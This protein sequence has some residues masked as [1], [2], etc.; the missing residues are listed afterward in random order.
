MVT[1]TRQAL[2]L[3]A[4]AIAFVYLG[5]RAAFTFNFTTPYAICVSIALFVAELYTGVL[6]L[7]YIL[8]VWW[9]S[10]PEQQPVLPDRTLDVYVPTYNEDAAMLR[11]TLRAC[12]AMDYPHR[13]FVLDDGRRPEIAA[14]AQELGVGYLTR[15]DN[16]HAKA[17][18]MN[19]A[20]KQ[21][22]GEFIVILDADHVPDA[23]F[24]TR[25]LGYFA[26]ETLAY[27]QTPH[28]FYNFDNFQ[29]RYN[30]RK[31]TYWDEGQLFYDVIQPGRNRW[32]AAIFAGS[33]AIFRRKALEEIGGFAFETITEDLHTGLRLHAR[34]WKS[35]AIAERLIAGQAAPDVTTFHS[36]RLRWGEGNLSILAYDNPLF[37]RGLSMAQ[38][39]CYLG[40]MIHWAGGPFLLILY[41]TPIL[42]LLTGVPPV[43]AFSWTFLVLIV[44][45]MT[46]SYVSFRA[47]SGGL[48]SYWNSQLFGMSNAW[49]S[50]RSVFRAMFWRRFQRFVVTSKRGRQSKRVL[51][52][53]WPQVTLL[54]LSM[55]ALCWGW[56][57]PISGISD[58]YY[59]PI[60]ASVWVV[61]HMMIAAVVIYRSL[62]QESRRFSYRHVV[63][64]PVAFEKNGVTGHGVCVDLNDA[65][66]G[67]M[68]FGQLEAGDRVQ[69]RLGVAGLNVECNAEV[70]WRQEIDSRMRV[71]TQGLRA[72][73]CGLCFL[74][75]APAQV[76]I[77]NEICWHYAVPKRYWQFGSRRQP[78]IRRLPVI[79][80]F[81]EQQAQAVT[82]EVT[83]GAFTALLDQAVPL[84]TEVSFNMPTPGEEVRGKARLVDGQPRNLAAR[85]YQLSRFQIESLEER[86][87]ETLE[88]LAS[89]RARRRLQPILDAYAP[90]RKVPVGSALLAAAVLVVMLLPAE[91]LFFKVYFRDDEFLNTIADAEEPISEADRDRL[92]SLYTRTLKGQRYPSND[93]LVLLENALLHQ[94]LLNEARAVTLVLAKRDT[95]NLNLQLAY[96]QALDDTGESKDA[97]REYL[98][99]MPRVDVKGIPQNR[100]S[101][102]RLAA[103]RAAAHAADYAQAEELFHEVMSDPEF[104]TPA[105]RN[106]LAGIFLTAGAPKECIRLY[107]RQTPDFDGQILLARAHLQTDDYVDAEKILKKLVA[108]RPRDL[109]AELLLLRAVVLQEKFSEA[110]RL[111]SRLFEEFPDSLAVRVEMGD[112]AL[113]IKDYPKALLLFQGLLEDKHP[114]GNDTDKVLHGYINAAA[115]VRDTSAIK[116]EIVARVV[117][118]FTSR[119]AP[120]PEYLARLAWIL[121]RTDE[122]GQAANILK[123]LLTDDAN[124]AG[125][126]ER[127]VHALQQAGRLKDAEAYLRSLPPSPDVRKMFVELYLAEKDY[128]AA[129]R[130]CEEGLRINPYA[131]RASVLL[132]QVKLSQHDPKEARRLLERVRGELAILPANRALLA[133]TLQWAGDPA[134]AL[135]EYHVLLDPNI[136]Q[137]DL[138]PGFLGAAAAVPKLSKSDGELIERIADQVLSKSNDALTLARLGWDLHRLDKRELSQKAVARALE[139]KPKSEE[140]RRELA[141]I[142]GGVG[143]YKEAI[144]MLRALPSQPTDARQMASLDEAVNDFPAAAAEYRKILKEQPNDLATRERLSQV[145][146]WSK[147]YPDA[148]KELQQLVKADPTKTALKTQLAQIQLWSGDNA[149]SL[150]TFTDLLS[151]KPN[152]PDLWSGFVDASGTAPTLTP[153]EAAVVKAIGP[154]AAAAS[155][156]NP[157]FLSRLAWALFRAGDAAQAQ[158]LIDRAVALKP[159]EPE[160]RK[161]I[162]GV[163]GALGQNRQALQM[164]AG[165]ELTF[166][167]RVKRVHLLNGEHDFAA[168]EAECRALLKE[169]PNAPGLELLLADILS[170]RGKYDEAAAMLHRLERTDPATPDLPLRLARVDLWG[171]KYDAALKQFAELYQKNR[172]NKE[173]ANGFLEAAAASTEP[174]DSR[175]RALLEEIANRSMANPP[176]DAPSLAGLASALRRLHEPAKAITLLQRAIALDPNSRELRLQLAEALYAAGRYDEAERNFLLVLGNRTSTVR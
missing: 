105:I 27:V 152:Q 162:A 142:L 73:R 53:I 79:L 121:E 56:Y 11:V 85:P 100:R 91:Y 86:G 161:E 70:R 158:K 94:R 108:A 98:E 5:Y 113:T 4:I 9:P 55:A 172:E 50:T 28:A 71:E 135:E 25:L 72:F 60:I 41:L 136:D 101:T 34:G 47:S 116:P 1:R 37:T 84:G 8:Q 147:N 58:D 139:L 65:G 7:L 17:G 128:K 38:R 96:A 156:D 59:K 157:V 95:S 46:L 36:Q 22:D 44:L 117:E 126:R 159:P 19:H 69:V 45:Y 15:P 141:G 52:F 97:L 29:S 23:N 170:W 150:V 2:L 122:P 138:W 88:A 137:P 63:S 110:G 140:A 104:D 173:L 124:A 143:M 20:L 78:D 115:S 145:L 77:L 35:I 133:N 99:L 10:E 144:A 12:V 54:L 165:L 83:S 21:T 107:D 127:Y 3:A 146:I 30:P 26:D 75:L 149:A 129:E 32:N 163:L 134:A 176:T 49:T 31:V 24:I 131:V 102:V 43:N 48:G 164:L 89:P 57:L 153:K 160:A 103:A 167:D 87:R 166:D 119:N 109:T 175:Y 6:M 39:F 76:D 120:E 106:E 67:L 92:L 123:Q 51:P 154:L 151:A 114:L 80:Q 40:S 148:I 174:L 18:N 93:R 33:A 111:I 118:A 42:M 13:T 74:D 81:A 169:K 66:I 16:K 14:L 130:V 68:A 62:W 125:Y 112:L 171:H 82:E 64:L 61:F 132:A 168:S 155:Q 90:A